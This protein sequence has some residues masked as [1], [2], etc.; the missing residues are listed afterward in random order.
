AGIVLNINAAD[1]SLND[2]VPLSFET[3]ISTIDTKKPAVHIVNVLYGGKTVPVRIEVID[4]TP[5]EANTINCEAWLNEPIEALTFITDINDASEVS[6]YFKS[7]PDFSST[8]IRQVVIIIEDSFKNTTEKTAIL[9]VKKDTEPPEIYGLNDKSV[10]IGKAVAYKKDVFVKDNK[11]SEV[12]LHIDSSNVDITKEG[13]YSVTYT[14][15]DS[16]GNTSSKSIKVTV[17]KETVS[18]DALNELVDGILDEILTEDMTKEQQAYAIYTWIR[19]N[20]RYESHA[21]ITDW[22]KEAHEGITTGF[23]DC[24]TYYIVSEVMLNRVNIDNMKVTRVGGSSN[25]YWNLV[26]CGSGWYHFDTCN[27]LDFK[28][29]FMLTDDQVAA[30]TQSRGIN[31]YVFDMDS[32]PRTPTEE[33]NMDEVLE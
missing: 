33:F 24:F 10:Y 19:G 28:P 2:G 4:T 1:F 14:A 27:F 23:G 12:E 30:L 22:I 20:I 26:N 13:T 16:S 15:T 32:Y 6:A 17:I 11:D 21:G 3:D 5:P 9:T 8:G 18:E 7:E 31:Y 29:T 25:H